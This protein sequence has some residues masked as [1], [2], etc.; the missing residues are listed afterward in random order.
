VEKKYP[1]VEVLL[2]TK[3]LDYVPWVW[4]GVFA[5]LDAFLLSGKNAP[6]GHLQQG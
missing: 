4:L 1:Q 5:R 6:L 2:R 3:Q